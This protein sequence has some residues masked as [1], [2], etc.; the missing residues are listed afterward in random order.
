MEGLILFV[1]HAIKKTER[2]T[3]TSVCRMG[4][5]VEARSHRSASGWLMRDHCITIEPYMTFLQ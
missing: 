4:P 3:G 2:G 5:M 1:M